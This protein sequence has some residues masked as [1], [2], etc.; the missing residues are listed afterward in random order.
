[1]HKLNLLHGFP[2]PRGREYYTK[3]DLVTRRATYVKVTLRRV[4]I[5]TVVVEKQYYIF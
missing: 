3:K 4:R 5:I 1:M 2:M